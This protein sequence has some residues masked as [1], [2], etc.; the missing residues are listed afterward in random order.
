LLAWADS[1]SQGMLP[2]RF[3]D[4]GEVAYNAV[5]A[6]LW[7]I[8][9]AHEFGAERALGDAIESI[10]SRY[11]LGT[12]HGIRMDADGLLACGE[13]GTQLT[14]MDARVDGRPVTPRVGKPVEV[15]ALWVNALRI[16]GG[17]WVAMARQACESFIERFWRED[18]G[19]LFDVVDAGHEA[20]QNDPS[21]RPNQ[22]FGVGGLPFPLLEGERAARVVEAVERRLLTAM[23]LRTLAPDEPGYRGRYAGDAAWRD[24]AYHQ[25]TAWPWLLGPFVEAWLRVR[26]ATSEA[27]AEARERFLRPLEAHLGEAGVGHVS[28]VADGDPPHTPGGCPFQAWSLGELMRIRRLL[29]VSD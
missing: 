18:A 3:P 23:G 27:K 19:C 29:S 28:E 4:D 1:L 2:N 22:I 24:G 25:G 14:W 17:Q 7:F 8:I 11:A 21:F 20:G 26:N 5:D 16:A 12:R 9:A 13:P 10:V 6:S 15:Q